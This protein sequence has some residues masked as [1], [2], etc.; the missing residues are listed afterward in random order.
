[1]GLW[2]T[3]G[4]QIIL[5]LYSSF[6][7]QPVVMLKGWAPSTEVYTNL[8]LLD[9]SKKTFLHILVEEKISY[10][11]WWPEQ[12]SW[13]PRLK[14]FMST[15][16]I[17]HNGVRPKVLVSVYSEPWRKIPD[18]QCLQP[19]LELRRTSHLWTHFTTRIQWQ[20]LPLMEVQVLKMHLSFLSETYWKNKK[21][22]TQQQQTIH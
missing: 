20:L 3:D 19:R 4:L 7:I 2:E 10:K 17:F 6:P 21:K 12:M 1:M 13:N 8:S 14:C 9:L 11:L 5:A 18:I 15:G 16:A 22:K